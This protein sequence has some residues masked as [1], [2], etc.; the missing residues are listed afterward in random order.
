MGDTPL[1]HPHSW[2]HASGIATD[3]TITS[4]CYGREHWK[5]RVS[6][7]VVR[8]ISA[9]SKSEGQ[10]WFQGGRKWNLSMSP[11]REEADILIN[12][13]SDSLLT[14]LVNYKCVLPSSQHILFV[15]DLQSLG[16]YKWRRPK[17]NSQSFQLEINIISMDDILQKK[18]QLK[19]RVAFISRCWNKATE[20]VFY[21]PNVVRM[22]LLLLVY[23]LLF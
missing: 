8:F 17:F 14:H 5:L 23:L 15:L 2:T 22:F 20:C 7:K 12:D 18:T 13:M 16:I 6:P 4:C 9:Q 3:W 1:Y 11:E 21:L 19:W 10:P